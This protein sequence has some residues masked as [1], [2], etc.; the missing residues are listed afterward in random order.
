MAKHQPCSF[1]IW[2]VK[3]SVFPRQ[4][5][6]YAALGISR[7]DADLRTTSSLSCDPS[8]QP[9]PGDVVAARAEYPSSS[10][11][12]ASGSLHN[13]NTGC[14]ASTPSEPQ[15]GRL[16]SRRVR[17]LSW[18]FSSRPGTPHADTRSPSMPLPQPSSMSSISKS[19]IGTPVLTSTTNAR[20]ASAENIDCSDILLPDYSKIAVSSTSRSGGEHAQS[21][22][23]LSEVSS[24]SAT[25]S[26][27]KKKIN[28]T[29][30][31]STSLLLDHTWAR[32]GSGKKESSAT[33]SAGSGRIH[34]S[35]SALKDKLHQWAGREPR[36]AT[37][38]GTCDQLNENLGRIV[39]TPSLN[40][41]A[42]SII[43][44]D[45]PR[46]PGLYSESNSDLIA[47]SLSRSFAS[48]VEKLDFDS[49]PTSVH[50]GTSMS[51][52][53][54]AKSLWSLNKFT[55]DISDRSLAKSK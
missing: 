50:R 19:T 23:Q 24:W 42:D 29:R 35:A 31:A 1:A 53:R 48:A 20:V 30:R 51:R 46:L 2:S 32:R 40:Q 41:E 38:K 15:E 21:N 54:K 3:H 8:R 17:P 34:R 49:S 22:Q 47:T 37:N 9:L 43:T 39:S 10:K 14:H 16:R 7:S 6:E 13:F 36:T 55:R 27:V 5:N 44:H 45:A 18:L 25:V 4:A 12:A 11:T 52:L 28:H 26:S 33:P